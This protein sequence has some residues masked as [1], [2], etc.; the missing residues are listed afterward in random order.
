MR[1]IDIRRA[2]RVEM[3][4]LHL[5]DPDTRIV[6]E[7][8]LCQGIAR[9]DLAVVNG[10]IHGYE[11]KSERDTLARL[12]SQTDVYSR[13]LDFV[14][15]ITAQCHA[16][17]IAEIVPSWWGVW[18][19]VQADSGFELEIARVNGRNPHI[20]AFS[21]AQ[22]L[23]RDEALQT[24]IDYGLAAGMRSKPREDLWRRLA[25]GLSV[26]ELG[27]VVRT[28]LKQRNNDWRSPALQV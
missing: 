7:L 28:R 20:N 9:V 16:K 5:N 27:Q 26:E 2:L 10:D 14:T 17:K 13:T 22:L 15:I 11:I 18:T 4:R 8:G 3:R 23:W 25:S 12:P 1:D 24:L 6:E 19:V 21:F